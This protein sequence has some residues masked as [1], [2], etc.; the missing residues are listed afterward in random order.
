MFNFCFI[1]SG[2]Q[3]LNAHEYCKSFSLECKYYAVFDSEDEKTQILNTANFLNI[4]K[5][6]L[7][8][9]KKIITYFY[10]LIFFSRKVENFIFGNLQD[11][12]MLFLSKM[13]RYN[14]IILIDDGISTIKN[15]KDYSIRGNNSIRYPKELYFFSIFDL[16]NN[17]FSLKNNFQFILDSKKPNSND[18]FFIGQPMENILGET[19]YYKILKKIKL[20]NPTLTYIAHRRDSNEKL[21]II[22]EELGIE[23]LKLTE[24]IELYLIKSAFIPR[25]IISFYSTSL[26]TTKLLFKDKITVNFAIENDLLSSDLLCVFRNLKIKSEI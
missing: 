4:K 18:V 10:L 26:I 21:F 23:V 1:S 5:I 8:K 6:Y 24:I 7:V 17:K 25:K 19:E 15:Y 11:N 22:T 9:R 3:L 20:L 16:D 13:L 12:H 2:F 14:K